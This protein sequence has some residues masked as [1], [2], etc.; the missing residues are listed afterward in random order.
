MSPSAFT[1]KLCVPNDPGM[2]SIVGE[3]A[4][5]AA[6]YAKLDETAATA[7]AGQ[8]LAAAG[9][10]LNGDNSKSTQV[11]FAAAN[12]ALTLTIG[13]QSITHPLSS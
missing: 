10:A 2:A 8:A 13:S 11:I 6:D 4:R 1:F 3:M 7:F 12:G 9:K 5:H